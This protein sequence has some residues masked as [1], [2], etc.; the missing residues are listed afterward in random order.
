MNESRFRHGI[1]LIAAVL[2]SGCAAESG[3]RTDGDEPEESVGQ[4][5]EALELGSLGGVLAPGSGPGAASWGPGRL[6]VFV[7]GGDNALW[8]KGSADGGI[9][10]SGWGSL[11]GVLTSDP[12]AV[13]WGPG[14]IDVFVRSSDNA[15]WQRSYDQSINGWTGWGSLG[16]SASSG[17]A[18]ASRGAGNIDLIVNGGPNLWQ[19][20]FSTAT[21]W[22]GW[23]SLGPAF[24]SDPAAVSWGPGRLDVFGRGADNT[25]MHRAWDQ[26]TGWSAWESLGGNCASGPAVASDAPGHLDVFVRGGAFVYRKSYRSGAWSDWNNLG[27]NIASDPAAVA[28]GPG[29]VALFGQGGDGSLVA[30][31]DAIIAPPDQVPQSAVG[32]FFHANDGTHPPP[33]SY[34]RG[35]G[36]PLDQCPPGKEKD[37]A[38]CYPTCAPGYYGVG[39][40]CWQSCPSG[41]TDTGALCTYTGGPLV[42]GCTN[43]DW[44]YTFSCSCPPNYTNTGLS[45]AANTIA[46]SSYGRTAGTPLICDPSLEQDGALCYPRCEQGYDGVGPVCWLDSVDVQNFCASLYDSTL[47]GFAIGQGW[48]TT[49][50]F[51]AGVD[52]GASVSGETGVVYGKEGHYG[53]YVQTCAGATTNIGV[54]AWGSF[55]YS[56]LGFSSVGGTTIIANGG[57]ASPPQWGL[58]V[59]AETATVRNTS[60]EQV[61]TVRSVVIGN[62]FTSM[63]L[64]FSASAITCQTWVTQLW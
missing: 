46:K 57:D 64:P 49:Y 52:A 16:G 15:I 50:G 14:R 19:R 41:Y 13:S 31:N 48:T 63:L 22:S 56:S 7:R 3:P 58:S 34:G 32:Q 2:I 1:G 42:V 39:P 30:S 20:S 54:N 8:Q 37:G 45:C 24:T 36:T 43:S 18:V 33:V 27:T 29:K 25:L 23:A 55:G 12:A 62:E 51:G 28:Y 4:A 44:W 11:G 10:W 53:C 40:V 47:A 61:R 17:P 21:G 59:S 6:D 9:T 35:A 26:S 38:L 5:R 60:G